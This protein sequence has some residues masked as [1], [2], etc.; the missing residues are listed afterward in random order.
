LVSNYPNTRI[1]GCLA[2]ETGKKAKVW[3]VRDQRRK[4]MRYY[5]LFSDDQVYKFGPFKT[6]AAR[7][8]KAQKLFSDEGLPQP[9]RRLLWLDIN[10]KGTPSVGDYSDEFLSGEACE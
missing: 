4:T 1:A 5:V 7:D 8:A 9:E 6:K 3:N 10:E 2:T